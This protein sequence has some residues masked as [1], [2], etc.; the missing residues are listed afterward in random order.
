MREQQGHWLERKI[1]ALDAI[2]RKFGRDGFKD[3]P[4]ADVQLLLSDKELRFRDAAKGRDLS[5]T[6][7]AENRQLELEIMDIR[8]YLKGYIAGMGGQH[9]WPGKRYDWSA[10][11]NDKPKDR[12][13]GRDT[14]RGGR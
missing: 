1:E 2:Y 8:G 12:D 14:G 10:P 9:V 4:L 13:H 7:K 5:E 11:E 3:Q 6:Q